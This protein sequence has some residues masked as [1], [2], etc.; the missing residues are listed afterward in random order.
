M[1]QVSRECHV[2][3]MQFIA[4]HVF[5]ECFSVDHAFVED[6]FEHIVDVELRWLSRVTIVKVVR[7]LR[8]VMTRVLRVFD[9]NLTQF[10]AEPV[11]VLLQC[12]S[13]DSVQLHECAHILG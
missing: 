9:I 12:P 1:L 10:L 7:N 6:F 2:E 5:L 4:R 11:L 13:R 3:R 8:L